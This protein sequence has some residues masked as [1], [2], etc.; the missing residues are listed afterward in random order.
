MGLDPVGAKATNLTPGPR[1]DI[2]QIV[3]DKVN[4]A[5][6][7]DWREWGVDAADAWFGHVTRKTVKRGVMTTPYGLT[8]IGMRDQL[9]KDRWCEDL[10][11]D[12]MQNANYLRDKMSEAISST[13]VKGVEIMKWF[14]DCAEILAKQGRPISWVTPTGMRVTQSYRSM[15]DS[16]IRTLIGRIHFQEVDETQPIAQRKQCLSIAPNIIHSFDAAHMMLSVLRMD[17]A[18][19]NR[20]SFSV[21]HDSF[22]CHAADMP[23]FISAIRFSFAEIYLQDWFQVFLEDFLGQAGPDTR[24]TQVPEKGDLDITQVLQAEFFFA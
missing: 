17:T 1:Q 24:F 23:E 10:P 2:Y 7:I 18:S 20:T 4:E 11:G 15:R 14:Q 8:P 5:V 19:D 6:E 13:I 16:Q 3:A 12:K 21:V 22:G 9:I